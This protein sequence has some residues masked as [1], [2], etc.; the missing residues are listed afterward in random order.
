MWW[1]GPGPVCAGSGPR[2]RRVLSDPSA[3]V[4]VVEHRNRLARFGAERLDAA[5][6]AYGRRVAVTAAG[7]AGGG[8]AG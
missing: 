4:I 1:P 3:S 2:L 5:L 7:Q 6:A 8:V